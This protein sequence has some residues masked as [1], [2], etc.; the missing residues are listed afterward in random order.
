MPDFLLWIDTQLA[1]RL[2]CFLLGMITAAY[3]EMWRRIRERNRKARLHH[4]NVQRLIEVNRHRCTC[5]HL[6][7][8]HML[9]R[10]A[11]S[12]TDC[13]KPGCSCEE[14]VAIETGVLNL[15]GDFT[16]DYP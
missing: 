9:A 6:R 13:L 5:G 15:D 1:N 8:M 4:L 7:G 16:E 10:D 14:Y 12:V 11:F 3:L 2:F